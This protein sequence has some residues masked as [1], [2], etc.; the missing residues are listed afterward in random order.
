MPSFL[1]KYWK[2]RSQPRYDALE[3]TEGKGSLDAEKLEEGVM[4]RRETRFW[5]RRRHISLAYFI[6]IGSLI[7]IFGLGMG[8]LAGEV[9][10][11]RDAEIKAEGESKGRV[12]PMEPYNCPDSELSLRREWSTLDKIEKREY[13][14]AVKCLMALP[15]KTKPEGNLFEDFSFVRAQTGMHSK[16]QLP[17]MEAFFPKIRIKASWFLLS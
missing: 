17:P 16:S 11:R 12:K 15:S 14:Q 8:Y 10:Q 1:S 2:A 5:Y 9:E 3:P 4:S 7:M 13:I 6:F